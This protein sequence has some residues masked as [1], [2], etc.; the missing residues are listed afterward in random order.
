MLKF[1]KINDLWNFI[2]NMATH[3]ARPLRNGGNP[4][5]SPMKTFLRSL[6]R[7]LHDSVLVRLGLAMGTLT[8][9]SFLS[10]LMSTVIADSS[11]GKASAINL[12]GSLRMMSFRMLSEIQQPEKRKVVP[13]TIEQFERRL[14]SLERFIQSKS[15]T[16]EGLT[17]ANEVVLEQWQA[18]I[19]PL[20][21]A[22]ADGNP[23]ALLQ[24]AQD[25]PGFV[26]QIDHVVVLIEED[27]E[28]KIHLLRATQFALLGVIILVSLITSWMLRHQLVLPLADLV[29]AAR[30]VSQGSF[31]VRVQHASNDE[32]G[33]LGRAF[34]TMISEIANMY[35]HLEEKV[36]EKTQELTRTNKSLELL[37]RTSQQLSASDLTLDTIQSV[38]RDIEK[39]LDLGHS[40]VCIS[41][42]GAFPAQPILGSLDSNELAWLCTEQDCE[43][44]FNRTH[45]PTPGQ[46]ERDV[47]DG[48]KLLF[49]P[50]GNSDQL[51]GSLPIFLKNGLSLPREK[52][53]VIET[54]GH[55][56]SN[57]LLNMRRADEKHR[58]AVLE[59]RAVIARELHDSIA[60]SL[61]Y[62]KIQVA[63]LEKN[64]SEPA[65]A[66]AITQ[67]L[68][69]GLNTAYKELRELITT[70]RLRIDERGFNT[71]L[72]ETVE[73]YAARLGFDIELSNALAGIALS[74]NEEMHLI[75]I[76]REAL[77]NIEKHAEATSAR[78]QITIQ[79]A[80][81]LVIVLIA[82]NGRGFDPKFIPPNH[83][84]MTIMRDR[85]Q[86][87]GGEIDIHSR[88]PGGT[89]ITLTFQPQKYRG[90]AA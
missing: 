70:F 60:Q 62:L 45:H 26:T 16:N 71:A 39:E 38:M 1:K 32:L 21:R 22:A 31:S 24:M 58:L 41:E 13:A 8:L 2:K 49:V 42:N 5:Y 87:L 80:Q 63:R 9:L 19:R 79:T 68:K 28:R 54:V 65:A 46:Q 29:K 33:Q 75:R 55:H 25:I 89:E 74:G 43:D 51:C 17:L 35:A 12:S 67:E 27:L 37:Y 3:P 59:E 64:L 90:A 72:L 6:S 47:P 4:Q 84:G 44:C 30:T 11:S 53:R 82:D 69:N 88:T 56:V 34:N 20:A 81:H 86:S 66:R 85:A 78:I 23:E 50:L 14:H 73:E 7:T 18:N 52:T 36:E 76:I 83:Y 77:N 15:S 48:Q 10:I 57:A 61:S 40:M